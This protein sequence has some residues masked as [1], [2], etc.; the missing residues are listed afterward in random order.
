MSRASSLWKGLQSPNPISYQLLKGA[1]QARLLLCH[2]CN[3]VKGVYFLT[4]PR[5][6]VTATRNLVINM[7]SGAVETLERTFKGASGSHWNPNPVTVTAFLQHWIARLLSQLEARLTSQACKLSGRSVQM[8][9]RVERT[10]N[11]VTLSCPHPRIFSRHK[12]RTLPSWPECAGPPQP[13]NAFIVL[14]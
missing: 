14:L 2:C 7:T 3:H 11:C 5:C 10:S 12:C 6:V 4:T 8:R 13:E 9:R 1:K